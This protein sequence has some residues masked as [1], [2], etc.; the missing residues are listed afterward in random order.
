[1]ITSTA[2]SRVERLTSGSGSF[3]RRTTS[4][5]SYMRHPET[6]STTTK[7]ENGYPSS[8]VGRSRQPDAHSRTMSTPR[9]RKPSASAADG[10]DAHYKDAEVSSTVEHHPIRPL[11][12]PGSHSQ[13]DTQYVNML[14]ALDDIPTTHNIAA[15]FFNWI[16]LAGF[17]LFPGT[18]ER[19]RTVDGGPLNGFLRSITH[20]PL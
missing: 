12:I 15:A 19:L 10:E 1:M 17:I 18:F 14:L 9:T 5:T 16:L 8:S 6:Q 13:M 7:P 3:G 11:L 20:L 2:S 4:S